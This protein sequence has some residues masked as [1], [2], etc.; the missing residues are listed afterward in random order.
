VI[1]TTPPCAPIWSFHAPSAA[2]QKIGT[3]NVAMMPPL[4]IMHT[5]PAIPAT[6]AA[7]CTTAL[8]LCVR[9]I[10][11]ITYDSMVVPSRDASI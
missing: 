6:L 4:A 10:L 8:Y 7:Q 5:I 1:C 2:A 3:V 11:A 9:M